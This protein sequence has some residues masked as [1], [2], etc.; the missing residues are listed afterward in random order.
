MADWKIDTIQNE[1]IRGTAQVGRFGAKTRQ[2]R[3]R[4]FGVTCTGGGEV[5]GILGE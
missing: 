4:C 5:M 1:Y 2:A 3:L